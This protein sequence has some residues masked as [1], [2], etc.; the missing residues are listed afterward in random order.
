MLGLEFCLIANVTDDRRTSFD[1]N[2]KI[3]I[4]KLNSYDK[5]KNKQTWK[6]AP[7]SNRSTKQRFIKMAGVEIYVIITWAETTILKEKTKWTVRVL[8]AFILSQIASLR[9]V[10]KLNTANTCISFPMCWVEL[11]PSFAAL[12]SRAI[13]MFRL[14]F[15]HKKTR[16]EQFVFSLSCEKTCVFL[17]ATIRP[18]FTEHF[19]FRSYIRDTSFVL[20]LLPACVTT[21]QST[22]KASLFVNYYIYSISSEVN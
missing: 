3:R 6:T 15:I 11:Q 2:H 5:N 8:K 9:K 17:W 21:E 19:T 22:V 13:F 18:N 20:W 4:L 16:L 12:S 7:S 10:I 1:R 14:P